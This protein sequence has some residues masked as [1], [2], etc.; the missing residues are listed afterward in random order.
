M[1]MGETIA[2]MPQQVERRSEIA[3]LVIDAKPSVIVFGCRM[4]AR[5]SCICATS[6]LGS[7]VTRAGNWRC[8]RP[9]HPKVDELSSAAP[10]ICAK[11]FS[12]VEKSPYNFHYIGSELRSLIHA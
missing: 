9:F 6:S 5:R 3:A 1:V 4:S 12:A 7:V 11:Y 10:L 8:R 2:V